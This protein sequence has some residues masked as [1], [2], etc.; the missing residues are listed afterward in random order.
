MLDANWLTIQHTKETF[1][2][3]STP[4]ET[5]KMKKMRKQW[6][7]SRA[8]QR[9]DWPVG[10]TWVNWALKAQK[11]TIHALN[12]C[13]LSTVP[14]DT[15]THTHTHTNRWRQKGAN[16]DTKRAGNVS[17]KA[18]RWIQ[19]LHT[20]THHSNEKEKKKTFLT[21][22]HTHLYIHTRR[23]DVCQQSIF[24]F[25]LRAGC[26]GN[27]NVWCATSHP[28]RKIGNL[29]LLPRLFSQFDFLPLF[30]LLNKKR[31]KSFFV[32]FLWRGSSFKRERRNTGEGQTTT[33]KCGSLFF[34]PFFIIGCPVDVVDVLASCYLHNIGNR[35]WL[36]TEIIYDILRK[37]EK[38]KRRKMM[39]IIKRVFHAWK[40]KEKE[41]LKIEVQ[42]GRGRCLNN[43]RD[44]TFKKGAKTAHT[45]TPNKIKMKRKKNK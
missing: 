28:S 20:H 5:G 14:T 27:R 21:H 41:A 29:L 43:A 1:V 37:K 32:I 6:K 3:V 16:Q 9:R 22:T 15:H 11:E 17:R 10:T 33:T 13:C 4:N 36:E 34:S 39:I 2:F 25:F 24:F 8:R 12:C 23:L 19:T 38:R 30:W 7:R 45:H 18:A 26:C 42:V 35:I 31:G 44:Y 40:R